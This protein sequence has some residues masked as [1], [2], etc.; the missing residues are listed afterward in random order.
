MQE[1]PKGPFPHEYSGLVCL[2]AQSKRGG[3][4]FAAIR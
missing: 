1:R 2:K 4:H 3:R